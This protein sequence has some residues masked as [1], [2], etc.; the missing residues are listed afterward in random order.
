MPLDRLLLDEPPER[1]LRFLA[2]S[3]AALLALGVLA[4]LVVGANRPA[5][6]YLLPPDGRLTAAGL[7][8][9]GT[10]KLTVASGYGFH[11]PG[12]DTCALVASSTKQQAVGLMGQTSL[13]GFAGMLFEFP[14]P[15]ETL[16]YMK[17]TVIPL[18]VAWFGSDGSFLVSVDMQPCPSSETI[19]PTYGPGVP[20]QSAL[21]VPE[22]RLGSL[23]IGPGSVL[24]TGGA[25]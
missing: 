15:T 2:R 4:F 18:T 13:H 1:W 3:S 23:G 19:C 14:S 7:P 21:E 17:N 9:F 8:G 12:S 10:A 25:C 11:R 6:P 5:N 16:F 20:Y 22:G 24:H